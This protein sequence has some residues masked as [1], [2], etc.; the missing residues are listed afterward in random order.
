MSI[1]PERN[2]MTDVTGL[3]AWTAQMQASIPTKLSQLTNDLTL[4]Y[5]TLANKPTLFSGVYDDLSNKP[6]LF[7]GKYSSLTAKPTYATVAISGSYTD[8]TNKPTIPTVRRQETY[9]GVT[10]A[11]GTYTVVFGTP[12]AVA[13]NI[14][15][16]VV[17]GTFNQF[18][19]TTVTT[20]GFSVQIGTRSTVTLLSTEVLLAATAPASGISVDVL[21]T[22]KS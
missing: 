10:D 1:C 9:S 20:T 13:P 5:T 7:D 4:S 21:V 17:G 22:A 18:A 14:Q 3:A 2:M 16:Q 15:T 11:T 19:K 8:L 6:V 12:Y